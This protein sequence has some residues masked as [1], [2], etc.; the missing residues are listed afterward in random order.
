MLDIIKRLYPMNRVLVGDDE[1][2]AIK[3]ISEYI[4]LKVI[5]IPSGT[6]CFTWKVPDRWEVR[7]A[8]LIDQTTGK[9]VLDYKNNPLHLFVGSLPFEGVVTFD[10]LDK[11]LRHKC[12]L[13][14]NRNAVPYAYPYYILDW[15]FCLS[16]NQ[17]EK[18]NR[19]HKYKVSIK[20]TY[21]KG[22]LT[23]GESVVKGKTKNEI[24]IIAHVDHPYQANDNLSAVAVAIK[25][26]KEIKSQMPNHTVRFLF[27]PET[28]GSI[29]YVWKRMKTLGNVKAVIA[30][31]I[32]GNK[33][34]VLIQRS[35]DENNY[36]NYLW[37]SSCK[38]L[39]LRYKMESFRGQIGSD[40]LIF[41]DPEFNI[42]SV[43]V[44]TWPYSQ[45]HTHLD[46][47]EIIDE[48]TLV[49]IKK[50]CMKVIRNYDRNFVPIRRWVGPLMRDKIGWFMGKRPEDWHLE[51]FGYKVDG[52][53]SVI[54]IAKELGMDVDLALDYAHDLKAR[55]LL[56]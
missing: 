51:L 52:K 12:L 24:L 8:T 41:S 53:K 26:A 4:P 23:I 39:N 11:H 43:M 15:G 21:K 38:S 7:G 30:L 32:V 25:V 45:Y 22:F 37:E 16:E 1:D 3:T 42:P 46:K 14:K 55:H 31:D 49:D 33:N 50:L 13:S 40:E 9:L 6:K 18:L 34:R 35:L 20:T 10:E 5:K 28:I 17:Y 36:I 27:L 29:V 48:K 2:K 56:E 19:K 44:S 54:E 47:P